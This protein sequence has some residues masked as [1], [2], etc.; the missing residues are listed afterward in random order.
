MLEDCGVCFLFFFWRECFQQFKGLLYSRQVH[1][2]SFLLLGSSRFRLRCV[3]QFYL[4]KKKS[5][6]GK[7]RKERGIEG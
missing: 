4:K 1:G 2:C 5:R 7:E 3:V 6:E